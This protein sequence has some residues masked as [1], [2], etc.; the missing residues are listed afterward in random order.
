MGGWAALYCGARVGAGHAIAGEPQT[1]LG[2]YLC[3]PAFHL[4]AEH[5]AGG[6]SP[7]DSRFLDAILF[8]ALR[9]APSPPHV[10]LYCGRESPYYEGHV[11]PLL[12]VLNELGAAWSSS[13]VTPPSTATS[14]STS[15]PTSSSVSTRCWRTRE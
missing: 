12:A 3:G 9:A 6:S 10:H 14:A 15:A 8:D 5:V 4:I 2:S 11:A 7:E 1:R 13:W